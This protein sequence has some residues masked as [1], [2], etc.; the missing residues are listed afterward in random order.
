MTINRIAYHKRM[1]L[2][3]C[4]L[5]LYTLH[6]LWNN[7][8]THFFFFGGLRIDG[9]VEGLELTLSH[10]TPKSQLAAEW[11]STKKIQTYQ[12][13]CSTSKDREEAAT[14]WQEGC[15]HNTLKSHTHQVS[16][17]HWKIIVSQRLSHRSEGSEPQVKPPPSLWFWHWEEKPPE[18]LALK[19][20]GA[21][22]Q[23]LHRVE[24]HRNPTLGGHT[25]KLSCV[26]GPREKAVISQEPQSDLSSGLGGSPG[27]TGGSSGPLWGQGHW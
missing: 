9:G 19:V 16:D 1:L 18:P 22:S 15:I 12:K 11:P 14:R 23:E 6:C 17:P 4:S 3:H 25:H 21:W 5:S 8:S 7:P 24:R 2:L 20:S 13:G 26:P 10:K 27:E